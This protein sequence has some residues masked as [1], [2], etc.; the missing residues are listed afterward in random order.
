MK[1]KLL[2]A[3]L[4]IV[5]ALGLKA[6]EIIIE[7]D[8]TAQFPVDWQG[9]TGA[10]GFVGNDFAPEVETNDGRT[11]PACERYNDNGNSGNVPG[12]EDIFTRTLTG[13]A[14]GTYSIELYGAAAYTP[15]RG[16]ATEM[17]EAENGDETAVYL[18]A[19]GINKYI[20]VHWAKNFN[21]GLETVVL[22]GVE[23]TDGTVKIGMHKEKMYTNWHVIQIKG[24]TAKVDAVALLPSLKEHAKT[25]LADVAYVN[26]IGK[27]REDLQAEIDKETPAATVEAYKEAID[28]I[29]N[30]IIKFQNVNKEPYAAFAALKAETALYAYKYKYAAPTKKEAVAKLYEAAPTDA[31]DA[32]ALREQLLSAYRQCI[33]SHALLQGLDG[34]QNMTINNPNAVNGTTGWITVL[35]KDSQGSIDILSNQSFTDGDEK[36]NY[37]YFDGGE[38]G[39]DKWDVTFQ[40]DVTLPVGKYMLS[41]TSRAAVNVT[42]F[43][44]FA[45]NASIGM[46]HIGN[47]GG[48]FNQGWNDN[49]LVFE[50]TEEGPVTIG[51]QGVTSSK[52]QWMSFT[53]FRLVKFEIPETEQ[54]KETFAE[55]DGP[56]RRTYSFKSKSNLIKNGSFEYP[57]AV[58]GWKTVDYTTD[59]IADNFGINITGAADGETYI[60]TNGGGVGSEKTLRQSVEVEPGK[61]Y[62]FAVYTSGKAPDAN[63]FQ[64]NALFKMTDEKTENG[65]IKAFEWPQGAA[66]TTAEWSLTEYIFT[67]ETPYVGVR[68]G[69]NQNTNFDGF[70]LAEI[71]EIEVISVVGNVQY[72]LD[73]IP[74]VNIGKNA[75]QYNE[76]ATAILEARAL[77]Q[78]EATVD[79]VMNAYNA[80][81]LTN[82][83]LNQP[84]EEQ[85]FNV[86]NV[87]NG[88]NHK[89]NTLTFRSASNAKLEENTTA[90]GWTETPGSIYPQAVKF[91]YAGTDEDP[92][93]YILSYTRAD[94][95]QV[96]AG[97]GITT[98]LGDATTNIRPTTE[99][100]KALKVRVE[101]SQTE[102]VW[103]LRNTEADN[104]R[105]GGNGSGD[106]GFFTGEANGHKFYDIKLQEA[107]E[108]EV[109]LNINKDNQ[110]GTL[111]VPFDAEIVDDVEVY[112]V[113]NVDGEKLEL[114]LVE[115][116]IKAN[117]PYI[118][119]AK[120]GIE[121]SVSGLGAAYT[122]A[123]STSGLLTG[124][125]TDID[126]PVGSY[127]LQNQENV[128]A[129]YHVGENV[130]P[131]VRANRAYLTLPAGQPV[132]T[133][134]LFFEGDNTTG[135]AEAVAEGEDAVVDVYTLSGVLVKKAV[136]RSQALD[137]LQKGLYIV[138]GTK[139]VK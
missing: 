55:D 10:T 16:I 11:T 93:L 22:D 71:E 131:K 33:E 58:Y 56:E 4:C 36:S 13:L 136:K 39:A 78:G 104:L 96:Y 28:A 24:V 61:K 95:K 119:Y 129:F 133:R 116:G 62:Y 103:Y 138:G 12:N 76:D 42:T 130:R 64:Y 3:M 27:I 40:Q 111:I 43:R 6:Q 135:V 126:A 47:T 137:G 88:Y 66:N 87:S 25:L 112:S 98:G 7:T 118:V 51:V 60:T 19:N 122:D 21:S 5:S 114:V 45:G 46:P 50:V 79:D 84:T 134:A 90:M 115:D 110:Y 106:A 94:G 35:G 54:P 83:P 69:W 52:E 72:A 125:Y 128:V 74:T 2:F 100:E 23:I 15:D 75:F 48:L 73:A 68:M 107:V 123:N 26:V 108:N 59:A 77:V 44:L 9:W 63:N 32:T 85:L 65:V 120:N 57:D 34:V 53:R 18:Y 86:V 121:T 41:V 92:N 97:T 20:P 82:L 102:N 38:W 17:T 29:Q 8:L 99:K 67:A 139:V 89:G 117:T 70:Y 113:N 127:V 80:L 31:D 132:N 81:T 124:T 109:T 91:T 37:Q 101:A 49:S 1:R 30:A 105:L 14:N